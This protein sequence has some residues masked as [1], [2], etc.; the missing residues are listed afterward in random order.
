M[1]AAIAAA[2]LASR[3]RE[4]VHVDGPFAEIPGGMIS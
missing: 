1:R 4:V 2:Y 3:G